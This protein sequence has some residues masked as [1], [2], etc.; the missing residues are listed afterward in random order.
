MNNGLSIYQKD[1]KNIVTNWVAA[2]LICG[3]ILLPSL[4]AWINIKA[5]W[6]PY[7]NTEQISVGVV[8]EDEGAEVRGDQVNVGDELVKELKKNKTM[9]WH[10]ADRKQAMDKVEYG[11]YFAVIVIPEDFSEKLATVVSGNPEKANMEYYVNEKINAIAPKIT[12]KGASVI[13]EQITS[14]FISIV[15]GVIFENFNELGLELEKDLPDIKRFED[16]VFKMEDALPEIHDMAQQSYTDAKQAQK[17]INQAQS[18]I[19]KA[20]R[21][22]GESLQII[23]E[24]TQFLNKA[25]NRLNELS[26]KV[27]ADLEKARDV[28]RD[29][30]GFIKGVKSKEIDFSSGEEVQKRLDQQTDQALDNIKTAKSLLQ[31]LKDLNNQQQDHPNKQEENEKID[32]AIDQLDKL[33]T[34]IETVQK[35]SDQLKSF[36]TD[37]EQEVDDT[38]NNLDELSGNTVNRIDAFLKEYDEN[39][40]PT[41]L[42]NIDNAQKTLS[43]ARGMLTNIQETI[44]EVEKI[45]GRTES[46]LNEGEEILSYMLN[47]Y[48]YVNGKINE[49]ADKIREVQGETDINEII[50]LLKN[51]PEKER[52]FFAEP[53]TL[54]KTELF[55]VSNYGTGMT[56]FYSVLA[57]WVGALLL[58]SLLEVDGQSLKEYTSR[59]RYFGKLLTFLTINLCQTLVIT[60]GDLYVVDVGIGHPGWFILFGLFI[61]LIFTT[62]VYTLVSIF[63]DL[64]KALAIVLLVLQIAGSGG[65]YPVVL[66]PEFFQ[67]IN[68]FLPFT[69][70]IDLV[71]EALAGIVWKRVT[72]DVVALAIFG[73]IA[74]LIGGLL[75][76]TLNKRT[77]KIMKKSKESGLF[78]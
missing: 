23:D 56:P 58:I 37:K 72:H 44:P 78:H 40:E 1:M 27:K 59:Q 26:P 4:Y 54:T 60:I 49:L 43:E 20:N 15:N 33:Q 36:V 2:I 52:N 68:P 34:D 38:L 29:V 65:T 71:R 69:Y 14:N 51:D 31:Q 39:I 8:N 16:Y 5:S 11:D 63:G 30:N 9:E 35:E 17:I 32:Q 7:G 74:L 42:Q 3:L 48:P 66:L 61:S 19:P 6:D 62:I 55:P 47:E 76:K 45:L 21:L 25:E 70:A 73:S 53:V 10:F 24:T 75:K 41:V 28:S 64:G 57:I 13:V 67:M 18:M 22:T 46:N 77:E 12:D 50:D